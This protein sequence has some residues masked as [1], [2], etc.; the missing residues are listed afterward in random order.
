MYINKIPFAIG[1]LACAMLTACGGGGGGGSS[2]AAGSGT[3]T[4]AAPSPSETEIAITSDNT[5]QVASLGHLVVGNGLSL[6]AVAGETLVGAALS[7]GPEV[8]VPSLVDLTF[9][10]ID[11]AL[12][13]TSS[14]STTTPVGAFTGGETVNCSVSG[15]YVITTESSQPINVSSGDKSNVRY[16]NCVEQ[17]VTITGSVSIV[18]NEAS[19]LFESEQA[20]KAT[21]T[22]SNLQYRYESSSTSMNGTVQAYRKATSLSRGSGWVKSDGFTY[23]IQRGEVK[24]VLKTTGLEV[25][26]KDDSF[27]T[28]YSITQ[29]ASANFPKLKG[30]FAVTTVQP[31]TQNPNGIIKSGSINLAGAGSKLMLS[32]LQPSSNSTPLVQYQPDTDNDG[33]YEGQTTTT[34]EAF[35]TPLW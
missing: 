20:I 25:T 7:S 23:D 13:R 17:G 35:I 34:Y 27:E 16:N 10:A 32:Y 12:D 4:P 21:T 29:T 18:I 33:K 31:L 28:I 5:S 6:S 19:G 8:R 26:F 22:F 2:T 9:R 14:T 30:R 15:N 24:S 3:Q 1:A 11:H